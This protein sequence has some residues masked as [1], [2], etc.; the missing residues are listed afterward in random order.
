VWRQADSYHVPRICFINKMDRVGADLDRTVT[1]IRTRLKAH[2]VLLQLPIEEETATGNSTFCGVIDL[3]TMQALRFTEESGAHPQ[4]QPIPEV[5]VERANRAR[6]ELVQR[7]AECD[8][9]LTLQYLNGAQIE[10]QS[11]YRV[12]RRAVIANE[13]TP[14][15]L[16]SALHNKGV[17]PLLDAIVRYLPSPLDVPAIQGVDPANGRAV[18]RQ[19]ELDSSLCALVFK[20]VMD[21]HAGR[22]AYTRIYSGDIQAGKAIYNASRK[23]RERAQRLLQVQANKYTELSEAQAGDIV[24][25]VGFKETTTGDT[26]SDH[27]HEIIL[28]AIDFPDPV[29]KVAVEPR[30]MAEQDKLADA[31]SK[32]SEEDPTFRREIDAQTGQT[33]ISGMGELHLEIIIERLHREYN[34]QCRVGT[35]QVAYR[36]A[37]Q[38]VARAEGS[39]IR[40]VGG[41]RHFAIVQLE[42]EPTESNDGFQ[43]K[44]RTDPRT[45]PRNFAAAVK[46]GVASAL[47][48]GVLLGYPVIDI[49]VTLQSAQFHESDSLADDFEIAGQIACRQAMQ[50]ASPV[51]MEP[52]MRVESYTPEESMGS[53]INDFGA[54][55]GE[56]QAMA[57]SGDSM[58]S[59]SAMTPLTGMIGYATALRSLTSGRGT[60]TMELDHYMP[61][62][63]ATH[64]RFLGAN[65]RTL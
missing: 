3:L 10:T 14:V 24:A 65:W 1:M 30:S 57:I 5:L 16:G 62:S 7:I 13:L 28:E 21:P 27:D 43:F 51:L 49:K 8:E 41:H 46:R 60:F 35:P 45:F 36:E 29:I 25:I 38:K 20:I 18:Q 37:I 9:T 34:V 52:V 31:L 59:V 4:L 42:I 48:S 19:P 58:R 64:E 55:H 26:L 11:L 44:D 61:A 32:L 50:Q 15:L 63:D 23:H 54:R 40:E 39:H 33:I 56:V 12:L 6:D 22:L 17:Q 47:Q 53:V 2:P